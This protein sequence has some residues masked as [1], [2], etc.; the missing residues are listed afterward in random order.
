MPERPIPHSG[1]SK[2]S[3][4]VTAKGE[5]HPSIKDS[6]GLRDF[7]RGTQPTPSEQGGSSPGVSSS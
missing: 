2:P 3:V 7:D 4:G 1:I 6:L 5:A